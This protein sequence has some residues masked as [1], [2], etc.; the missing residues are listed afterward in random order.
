[1]IDYCLFGKS[2]SDFVKAHFKFLMK[3]KVGY[4]ADLWSI[5][6]IEAKSLL[7]L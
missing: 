7:S 4:V 6:K 2:L 1:M 5:A 3:F